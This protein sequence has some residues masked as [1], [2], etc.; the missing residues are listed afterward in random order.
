MERT[1]EP[2]PLH[3]IALILLVVSVCVNYVD[4]G[5][6]GVALVDI[7]KDI[8]FSKE[9]MGILLGGFF[10]TYSLLQVA[11][12]KLIERYNV[13]WVYAAG[14]FI[15][16]VAT[17]FTGLVTGFGSL[18]SLRL[19][20]GAGESVAYP[21]YSKIITG[22]FPERLRGT[23]NAMIDAG[24]KLGPA[25]GVMVGAKL[26]SDFHWRG[27][28]IGIGLVSL[29]WLIPWGAVASRL[30][31][32]KETAD[33]PAPS[34]REIMSKRAFWGTA[35]GLF[36]GNYTWYFLITWLPYYFQHERGYSLEQLK[37]FGSLP[38][39]GVAASSMS[40]GLFADFLI[41]RGRTPARVRQYIVSLGLTLCCLF[42]L[43]AV[44]IKEETLSMTMLMLACLS[45]G[46]FS[47]NHWAFTQTLS[48]PDAAG[49]WTGLENCLGNFA[50]V[51]APWVTGRI[52]DQTHSFFSAF[53][54][55][56][57][58]LLFGVAGFWLVVGKTKRV[59][60]SIDET[61]A[62]LSASI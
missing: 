22:S 4:R 50:G 40:M 44:T 17:A 46:L 11:A 41:R 55:C 25:L 56:C 21:A 34:Y 61:P 30:E 37:F 8:P 29:L 12:G 18:F 42:M 19:L 14:Y 7:E 13:N 26:I 5:N 6:L 28:F 58:V 45:L 32:F 60:W 48:G 49:K 15:W 3:W 27:M 33:Q 43:P 16:S 53:A 24:S 10:W 36:G 23:A 9:Q 39:W 31:S 1:S 51:V 20:V 54:V 2:R 38:Y 35:L 47:S 62:V 59:R 52:L 57:V